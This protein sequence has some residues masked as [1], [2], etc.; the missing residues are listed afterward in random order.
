[1]KQESILILVDPN[2]LHQIARVYPE[3]GLIVERYLDLVDHF[4][5]VSKTAGFAL[6]VIC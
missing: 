5:P 1:M 4:T 2:H 3:L 6:S